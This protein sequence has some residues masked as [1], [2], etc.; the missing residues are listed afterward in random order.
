[1]IRLVT[2]PDK[3]LGHDVIDVFDDDVFVAGV[4]PTRTASG[5]SASTLTAG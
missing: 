4:Y 5:S 1:M 2:R 3:A